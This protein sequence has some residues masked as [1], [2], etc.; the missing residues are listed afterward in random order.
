MWENVAFTHWSHDMAHM[1]WL[2]MNPQWYP[3]GVV[4]AHNS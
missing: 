4:I 3:M 2:Q 1:Q